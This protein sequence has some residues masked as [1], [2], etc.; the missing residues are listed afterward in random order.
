MSANVVV[1]REPKFKPLPGELTP[2]VIRE[3]TLPV[4]V[5]AAKRAIA[6]CCDLSELLTWKD[7][8]AALAA[9]AKM[10][11][12]PEMARDVNR[13]HKEAIFRMGEILLTYKCAQGANGHIK[14]ASSRSGVAPG[15]SERRIAGEAVGMKPQAIVAAT[16]IAQAPSNIREAILENPKIPPTLSRMVVCTPKLYNR[17]NPRKFSDAARLFFSGLKPGEPYSANNGFRRACT[18]LKSVDTSVI[19][20]LTPIE[21][22]HVRK[23]VVEMQEILDEIDRRLGPAAK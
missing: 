19:S 13:V 12:M 7:K 3:A 15:K 20:Q 10:A 21:K 14:H 6:A 23:L 22:Q 18:S 8:L 5:E 1:F 11:R 2:A 17:A 16:R 9:A 4:K